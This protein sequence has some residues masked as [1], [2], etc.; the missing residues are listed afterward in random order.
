[1]PHSTIELNSK[2]MQ[3]MTEFTSAPGEFSSEAE[4]TELAKITKI[5]DGR[6]KV[7][8]WDSSHNYMKTQKDLCDRRRK[9]WHARKDYFNHADEDS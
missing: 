1:M 4:N 7:K 5:N 8:I 2:E 6:L 3:K 9:E